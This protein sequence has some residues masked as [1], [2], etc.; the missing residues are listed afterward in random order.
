MG[1]P[2]PGGETALAASGAAFMT[3]VLAQVA[4]AFACRSSTRWPGSLG[5][6]SNRLLIPAVVEGRLV[7]AVGLVPPAG[8]VVGA[9]LGAGVGQALVAADRRLHGRGGR[10]ATF[11]LRGW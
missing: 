4:N 10:P 6:T 2:F 8:P 5:W 1:E 7:N 3:V 9:K 11:R